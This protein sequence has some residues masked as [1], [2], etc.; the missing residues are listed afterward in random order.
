MF[1][2]LTISHSDI[3]FPTETLAVTYS[4]KSCF[5]GKEITSIR[6]VRG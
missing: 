1:L 2:E 5:L 3:A 4:K 6:N